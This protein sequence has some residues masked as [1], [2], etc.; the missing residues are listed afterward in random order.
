MERK[1]AKLLGLDKYETGRP[2]INNHITF[3]YT[4]TGSCNHCLN[5]IRSGKK[6]EALIEKANALRISAL[7][8]YNDAVKVITEN[9]ERAIAIADGYDKQ[10]ADL[11]LEIN[12]HAETENQKLFEFRQKLEHKNS[13]KTM[14]KQKVF[15]HPDDVFEA[16]EYLLEKARSVNANITMDDINYRK[17]IEGGV[18]HE[19]R[20]FPQH[21]QEIIDAT[22]KAY[23]ARTIPQ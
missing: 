10:A 21:Q 15:I 7:T 5:G 3:R 11:M 17:K 20:C 22:T 14:I 16:K 6:P 13:V 2:C 8:A 9:Y 18:L 4:S 1:E 23:N 12:A 19:I